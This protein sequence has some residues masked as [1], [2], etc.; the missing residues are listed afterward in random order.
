MAEVVPVPGKRGTGP[1]P[2]QPHI[3][4]CDGK[5]LYPEPTQQVGQLSSFRRLPS[6]AVSNSGPELRPASLPGSRVCSEAWQRQREEGMDCLQ[7]H[8]QGS[9]PGQHFGESP[10]AAFQ[11]TEEQGWG[12]VESIQKWWGLD[13]VKVKSKRAGLDPTGDMVW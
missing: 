1:C 11:K 2:A 13:S 5:V 6:T 8:W 7:G 4:E 9:G 10:L 3:T 12:F